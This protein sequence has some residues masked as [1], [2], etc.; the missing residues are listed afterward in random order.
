MRKQAGIAALTAATAAILVLAMPSAG[1]AQSAGQW[2]NADHVYEKIC[3]NCHD[4]GVG[5]LMTGRNFKPDHYVTVV[6]HGQK[7][8]PAFRVTEIDDAALQA[9]AEQLAAVPADTA[10]EAKP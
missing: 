5:P 1:Q 8:M 2:K 9:L 10:E 4:S 7:A 3:A 6:R